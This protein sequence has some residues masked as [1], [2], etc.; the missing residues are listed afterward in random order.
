[1]VGASTALLLL[2]VFLELTP[3]FFLRGGLN[4]SLSGLSGGLLLLGGFFL[5]KIAAKFARV[6]PVAARFVRPHAI[7]ATLLMSTGL[8]FGT[9]ASL[10]GLNGGIID[11]AQ[12]SI[13]ITAVILSAIIP[14]VLAQRLFSPPGTSSLHRR[15]RR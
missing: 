8:A 15:D 4:V 12:F 1:M 5:F 14:T 9:I 2:D 7:Y 11:R 10:Y 6:L 3:F 13:L